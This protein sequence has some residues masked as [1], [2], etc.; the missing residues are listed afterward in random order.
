MLV[1]LL[2]LDEKFERGE[3][4]SSDPDVHDQLHNEHEEERQ[5][6][7]LVRRSWVVLEVDIHDHSE[8]ETCKQVQQ[9]HQNDLSRLIERIEGI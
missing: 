8:A 4:R 6:E 5:D 1:E 2:A 3:I 9:T 7:E